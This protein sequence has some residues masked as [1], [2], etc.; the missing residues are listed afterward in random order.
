[1]PC[2]TTTSSELACTCTLLLLLL[3]F[4]VLL[5]PRLDLLREQ[6]RAGRVRV[7]IQGPRGGLHLESGVRQAGAYRD[8]ACLGSR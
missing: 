1:M 3:S 4:L 8:G 6:R 2:K 7:I 5:G